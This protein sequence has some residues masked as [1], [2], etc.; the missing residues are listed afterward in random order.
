MASRLGFDVD[1][2][3]HDICSS[4]DQRPASI[5]EGPMPTEDIHRRPGF[6]SGRSIRLADGQEWVFPAPV[7][8]GTGDAED[9]D[10]AADSSYLALLRALEEAEDRA[11]LR[12]AELA[13]TIHLLGRNYDLGPEDYQRLLGLT[14]GSPELA[15][16]QDELHELVWAHLEQLRE[17]LE[18]RP[19]GPGARRSWLA[20]A[21]QAISGIGGR[22]WE[23][24]GARCRTLKSPGSLGSHR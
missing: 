2:F 4:L 22:I 10:I 9:A 13:L 14:P 16:M 3:R 21:V 15:R 5:K 6:Q 24:C 8:R 20:H 18:S 12:R 19:E 11:E 1:L 7:T 23:R 17:R